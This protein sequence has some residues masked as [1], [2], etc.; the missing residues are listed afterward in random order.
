VLNISHI[1]IKNDDIIHLTRLNIQ[2]L[3]ISQNNI[4]GEGL[5]HLSCCKKLIHLDIS[6]T[7]ATKKGLHFISNLTSLKSIT[8]N[9]LSNIAKE[10]IHLSDLKNLETLKLDQLKITGYET[11]YNYINRKNIVLLQNKPL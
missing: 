5:I 7:L 8:L 4:D 1:S 9:N 2:S 3:N 6:G 11:I 10:L